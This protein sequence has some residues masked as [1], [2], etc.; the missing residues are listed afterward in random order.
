MFGKR[1]PVEGTFVE[2]GWIDV[3]VIENPTGPEYRLLTYKDGTVRFEHRCDRGRRG[4]IVCAPALMIGKGHTLTRNHNGKP[5]VR[6]SILCLDCGTH[7]Y[8]TD[9]KWYSS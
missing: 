1:K 8:I 5:T 7:G 4:S 6:A 2:P 3:D 9:G